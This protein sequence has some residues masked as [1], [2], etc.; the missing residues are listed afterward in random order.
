MTSDILLC[1][2]QLTKRPALTTA[3]VL[4]MGVGIAVN[5]AVFSVVYAVLLKPLPYPEAQQLLFITGTSGSG[6][7]M[8]GSLPDFRGWRTQ[9]HTFE[10]LA[11]YNVEDWSLVVNGETEHHAGAFVSANYLR[12]VQR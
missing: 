8:P 4:I 6:E 11:A 9:Q 3:I 5:A 12:A 1:L 7:Q 2:R 10:D